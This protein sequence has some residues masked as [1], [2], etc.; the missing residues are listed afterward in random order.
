[1]SID[2][3]LLG[4]LVCPACRASLEDRPLTAD[5]FCPGCGRRYLVRDGIPDLV[6][7]GSES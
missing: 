7:G 4:M 6:V 5:L 1:M 2:P 3:E